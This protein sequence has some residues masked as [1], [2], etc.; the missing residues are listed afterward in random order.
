M[1]IADEL[2][3]LATK[4]AQA[5]SVALCLTTRAWAEFG[6]APDLAKLETCLRQVEESGQKAPY[7]FWDVLS[8]SQLSLL[9]FFRGNWAGA[10]S[11]AEA[12]HSSALTEKSLSYPDSLVDGAVCCE[13]LSGEVI[14][15]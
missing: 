2:E 5:Y 9:D 8:E 14:R 13:L 4:I 15:C 6:K 1:R 11:H 3:P 12:G 7:A 10:L